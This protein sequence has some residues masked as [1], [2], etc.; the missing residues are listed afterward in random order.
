MALKWLFLAAYT[1][2]GLAG[3]IYEVAWTR[4]LTMYMGHSTAA[5]SSVVAAFMGGVA[6]GSALGGVIAPRLTVRQALHAYIALE[7]GVLSVALLLPLE[8]S[9]LIPVL[10]WAYRD[11]V[12][13]FL[14]PAIR[15][16]LC[17]VV[18]LIPA[19][20]L[21]ATFPMAARWFMRGSAHPGRDGG[22]LYAANTIGAAIGVLMAGFMLIPAIGISGTTWVGV[23]ASG[24]AVACVSLVVRRAPPEPQPQKSET[25]WREVPRA[26]A[27]RWLAAIVLGLSGFATFVYEIAWT[28]VL[29]LVMGPTTYAFAATLAAL[30]GG[31]ACGS[32]LGSWVAGRTHR[33]AL[34]LA[35]VLAATAIASSWTTSLVGGD[36]PRYV[37]QQLALTPHMLGPLLTR[38]ASMIAGLILPTAI[39]FGAAFPLALEMVDGRGPI[40]LRMGMVY[41]VNTLAA[42]AGSLVAGF[43]AI[44]LLGLQH[45]L[46]LVGVVLL[47]AAFVVLTWGKLSLNGRVVALLPSAA[48]L[49]LLIWSPPWDRELLASGVY[50]AG[51]VPPDVDLETILKAGTLLYYRDGAA[52]TV[53]VKRLAGAL[54]LAIDGKVDASSSGDMLNQKAAGHLPLLLHANPRDVMVI[55]LGSGVTAASALMHPI[56]RLDVVEISPEVVEA[57]KYFSAENRNVLADSRTRLILGDGR[58]HLLLSSKKY[59]AI[60]SEPSNPWMA[61]VAALFTREFFTAA[62]DHLAPD[63]IICQWAH[64]YSISGDD[65]RSIVATFLSVFPHGTMWLVG[66]GD[67]LL[68]AS[69]APLDSRLENV[70][71]AWRRPGVAADLSQVAALEPFA[72]LSLFVA[73]PEELRRYAAGAA[74]QTDDRMALE[75]SG[76]RALYNSV[77]RNNA[78][79]L[80]QLLKP[81][82]GPPAIRR[83]WNSA[84]A[85]QWRNR[86]A[87][88]LKVGDYPSAYRDYMKALALDPTDAGALEGVG[89][90]AV[91]T[92]HEAEAL[93]LL[94]S[95][96]SKYPQS[97]A[98]RVEVSKLLATTNAFDEAIAVATEAATSGRDEGP[99]L[100]QLAAIFSDLGDARRLDGVLVRLQQF[101][102][103]A[104]R[105]YYFAAT[106][107]FLH[108][109]FDEAVRLAQKAAALDPKYAAAQKLLGASYGNLGQPDAARNA[110]EAALRLNPRDSA[111]YVNLGLLES[112]AGNRVA[113][114]GYFAESLW[115]DPSSTAARQGLVQAREGM[116]R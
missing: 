60:I 106:S 9:A 1:C 62:R 39:G 105:T 40:A 58:S 78:S 26:P 27:R 44:P 67:V 49:A 45:T 41:A 114:A 93:E 15:L 108:G 42:V 35:L 81:G 32:T 77:D 56:E 109:R 23:A 80:R 66:E 19:M 73:G 97:S 17:L 52:S 68:V 36:V 37:A 61:G 116:T 71:G 54:S 25:E 112:A 72:L 69:T 75:F 84:G 111:T 12:P 22:E 20:A 51:R 8:F 59:D 6:G 96:I 47:I 21:G 102:P 31:I 101:Q 46:Q 43:V 99:A 76:P 63:G 48:A 14:F 7:A 29:S 70:E 95:S 88:M 82:D 85:E 38:H 103:D 24:L 30:I 10:A 74:L 100:E 33:P 113:G 65:L 79:D 94:K 98:I 53:S 34:W 11:G 18:V 64:T 55:G 104:A 110:F 107:K 57:S 16:L 115:L 28:R 92:R 86:A 90:M 4:L 87:M 83:A 89:P 3:L 2:S 91:A 5:A 50:H 13:G